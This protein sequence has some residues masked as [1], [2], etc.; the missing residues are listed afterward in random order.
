[1]QEL[2]SDWFSRRGENR[3]VGGG[4]GEVSEGEC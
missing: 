1:M 3:H 2:T 4:G